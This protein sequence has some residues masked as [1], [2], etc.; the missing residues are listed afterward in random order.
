[1]SNDYT[2]L[3]KNIKYFRLKSN[4]TQEQL[5]EKS[6][7]SVSYIKQIESGKEFKNITFNTFSKIA[8]ALN[9]D[10]KELFNEIEILN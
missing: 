2:I 9:I 4:M 6:D 1:M 7:L 10:V 8:K 5:A 3:V